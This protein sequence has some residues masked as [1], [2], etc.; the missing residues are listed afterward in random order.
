MI[1]AADVQRVARTARPHTVAG[2]T[3]T[4]DD[5]VTLT[6][7]T[8]WDG[9]LYELWLRPAEEIAFQFNLKYD[10]RDDAQALPGS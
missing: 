2:I 9:A 4:I 8:D 6:N 10:L 3:L 7:E 5:V 1:T